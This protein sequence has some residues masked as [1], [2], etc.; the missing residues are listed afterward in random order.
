MH[1]LLPVGAFLILQPA[2]AAQRVENGSRLLPRA[3]RGGSRVAFVEGHI[4]GASTASSTRAMASSRSIP[5]TRSAV[6]R[7]ARPMRRR[8]CPVFC[9]ASTRKNSGRTSRKRALESEAGISL[10][11][12]PQFPPLYPGVGARAPGAH[13]VKANLRRDPESFGCLEFVVIGNRGVVVCRRRP[14]AAAARVRGIL[15]AEA[16]SNAASAR[17]EP[18]EICT[19]AVFTLSCNYKV[20]C[21]PRANP[22]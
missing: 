3:E 6:T 9:P 10:R 19:R 17:A 14:I 18:R 7:S 4:R 11:H 22:K 15:Q 20:V 13:Y 1:E 5:C 8:I 2:R 21:P 12:R 16:A